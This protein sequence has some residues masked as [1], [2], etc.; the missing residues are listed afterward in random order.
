VAEVS[1]DLPSLALGA[2][3]MLDVT[4]TGCRQGDLTEAAL[5]TSTRFIE[6]DAAAWTTNTVRVMAR[7]ISPSA[8]FDLS[9]ITLSMGAT[10]R[11]V[12]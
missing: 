10:K 6:L 12:P 11:R 5:A 3:S 1:W 7:N 4:L 2:T 8:T 9:A